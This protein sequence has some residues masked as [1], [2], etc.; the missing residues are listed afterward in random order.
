[1]RIS[2]KVVPTGPVSVVAKQGPDTRLAS[3]HA[4]AGSDIALVETGTKSAPEMF[5]TAAAQN[6]L[7][8]WG[9]RAV[10]FIMLLFGFLLFLGPL[11]TMS[12]LIPFLGGLVEA[13][14][15]LVSLIGAIF[16]WTL[17]VGVAWMAVRP[18]FGGTFLALALVAGFFGIKHL[19]KH[20]ALKR[21]QTAA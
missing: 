13:G 6:R 16:V 2:E 4:K 1:L 14:I 21:V 3:F 19:R 8:T 12:S 5:A 20:A 15:F 7:L 17:L 9:L 11:S 18:L 10:G